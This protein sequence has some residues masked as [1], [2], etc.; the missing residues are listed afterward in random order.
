MRAKKALKNYFKEFINVAIKNTKDIEKDI[1][2]LHQFRVHL[3]KT[4]SFLIEFSSILDKG[5]K[6]Q[7]LQIIKS[8]FDKTNKA[9]DLDVF[10]IN[11]E[12][13]KSKINSSMHK[14]IEAIKQT[15]KQQKI[16][17][18][19]NIRSFFK[20]KQFT[21][22]I[23]HL[24]KIL[25]KKIYISNAKKDIKIISKA[26]IV[27]QKKEIEKRIQN[28][29]ILSPKELHKLRIKIK[30][31]RYIFEY[32]GGF[33][34]KNYLKETAKIKKAQDILGYAQDKRVQIKHLKAFEDNPVA[35]Y[36]ISYLQ[37]E[38]QKH[39][40]YFIALIRVLKNIDIASIK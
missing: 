9:R 10:L 15:V 40:D 20:N 34:D 16:E 31:Y 1:E 29:K 17:E 26:V 4:K 19:K 28:I 35:I 33:F 3:R 27:S 36:L 8:F 13:Y 18:Y 22:N 37:E 14:N 21:R 5:E 32:F 23:K 25:N 6:K 11:L 39:R 7:A 38:M 2:H 12:E 30:Q 24:K